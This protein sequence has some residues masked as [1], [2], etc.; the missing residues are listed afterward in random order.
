MALCE[1]CLFAE[2]GSD[3]PTRWGPGLGPL[4]SAGLAVHASSRPGSWLEELVASAPTDVVAMDDGTGLLLE[5]GRPPVTFGDGEV[6]RFPSPRPV[7]A[8]PDGPV[9]RLYHRTPAATEILRSGFVDSLANPV[10]DGAW[11]GSWFSDVPVPPEDGPDG[12]EVLV[13][14]VPEAVAARFAWED[15][16]KSYRQFVLPREVADRYGPPRRLEPDGTVLDVTRPEAPPPG[17]P[18]WGPVPA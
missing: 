8:R 4:R 10:R 15:A 1:R 11:E 5:P 6:R 7:P 14:E 16:A 13:L 17:E 9:L 3:V 18:P 2:E 12:D